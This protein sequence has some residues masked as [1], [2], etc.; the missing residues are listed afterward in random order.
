MV[1]CAEMFVELLK[2]KELRYDVH[3]MDDGTCFVRFPYQ[4][5]VTTLMFSGDDNGVH[6]GL[7][8][9]FEKCPPEKVP[10]LLVIC[11]SLNVQ[12]RWLKFCID[13]DNNIMVE[14][15][16]ILNPETAGDECFELLVRTIQIMDEVKPTIM[17]G[18]FL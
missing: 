7:R 4:G 6:V 13:N 14:D 17:R 5:R 11:N 8:T 12:F 10:D 3:E 15:D 2:S 16:A 1:I 9:V 18:I